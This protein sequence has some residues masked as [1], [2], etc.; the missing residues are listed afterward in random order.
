MKKLLFFK[1]PSVYLIYFRNVFVLTK[2]LTF[3]LNKGVYL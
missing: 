2:P 3:N 1:L